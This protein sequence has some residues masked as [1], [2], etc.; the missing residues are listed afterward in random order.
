M[1]VG[2]VGVGVAGSS[3]LLDLAA[4]D[5]FTIGAVCARRRHHAAR[6]ADLFG[7]PGIYDDATEMLADADLDA[8]VIATPPDLTPTLARIALTAGLPTLLDKP[9]GTTALSLD[10]SRIGVGSGADLAV[11]AYNRRY[12]RHVHHARELLTDGRLGAVAGVDCVWTAPFARRYASPATY[13]HQVGCGHGVVL[14]TASHVLDTL[15]FLGI[16]PLVAHRARLTRGATGADIAAR[17]E[18]R[19]PPH[20]RPVLIH[21]NDHPLETTWQITLRGSNG[22]LVLTDAQLVGSCSGRTVMVVADDLRRPVDDLVDLA[23]GRP[24]YGTPLPEAI[25]V[26]AVIDQIRTLSTTRH[27]WSRPRAKALGRLNGAC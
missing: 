13:R 25:T 16:H 2:V 26:L 12:Q 15:T 8:V 22:Y 11:V 23:D 6:A 20:E 14:D 5:R 4:S 10:E 24:G 18:L 17:I 27:P 19:W 3:H 9:A 21:I 7:V 1:K